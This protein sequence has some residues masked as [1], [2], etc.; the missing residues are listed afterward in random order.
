MSSAFQTDDIKLH[1][2]KFTIGAG[3]ITLSK[4]NCMKLWKISFTSCRSRERN[5]PPGEERFNF[6]ILPNKTWNFGCNE[7]SLIL[8]DITNARLLYASTLIL[9]S[10]LQINFLQAIISYLQNF[11]IILKKVRPETFH[12]HSSYNRLPNVMLYTKK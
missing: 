5:F 8:C 7:N 1:Q 6:G 10:G 11:Q 2:N 12:D 9:S 4:F 3:M